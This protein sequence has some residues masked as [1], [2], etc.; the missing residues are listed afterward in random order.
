MK[1][2][3]VFMSVL[4]LLSMCLTA[5]ASELPVKTNDSI[6]VR[7]MG[8]LNSDGNVTAEDARSILREAAGFEE[9]LSNITLLYCDM[10]FDGKIG[11]SDAR[12][13]LRTAVALEEKQGYAF[14]II[15][16]EYSTCAKEGYTK[17]KCTVTGK[18]VCIFHKKLPHTLPVEICCTGKEKCLVCGEEITAAITH[19]YIND[20][21]SDTKKCYYCGH[22]A[23]LNHVHSFNSDRICECGQSARWIFAQDLK[24]Y[25]KQ[26]GNKGDGYYYIEEYIEPMS[27]GIIYDNIGDIIYAFCG[28]AVEVEGTVLYYEFDYEIASDIVNAYAYTE[29]AAM[30]YARGWIQPARVKEMANGDAIDLIEFEAIPELQNQAALFRQMMEAAVYSTVYWLRGYTDTV[31]G[32]YGDYI[33][34][35]FVNIK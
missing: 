23:P 15:E 31:S 8:D 21:E 9:F 10:D 11:A 29:D 12:L 25:I 4:L 18:E 30:A 32:A 5:Y 17:G 1:I 35:D 16:D 6:A 33:F 24:K 14:E 2:L 19:E 26:H 22:I 27:F 20:Y 3:S 34:S 28:F 7:Y 13:A